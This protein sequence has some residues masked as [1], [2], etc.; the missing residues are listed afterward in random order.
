[1]IFKPDD[2]KTGNWS[3]RASQQFRIITWNSDLSR[4]PASCVNYG[5]L[6]STLPG[7]GFGLVVVEILLSCSSL[8]FK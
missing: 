1:M 5:A 8:A 2:K 7:T 6:A 3:S 4:C